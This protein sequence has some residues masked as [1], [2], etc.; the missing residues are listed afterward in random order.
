M[1]FEFQLNNQFTFEFQLNN[2][3]L[4][5]GSHYCQEHTYTKKL[6]VFTSESQM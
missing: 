4:S 3:L 6:F 1:T 2:K 5:M